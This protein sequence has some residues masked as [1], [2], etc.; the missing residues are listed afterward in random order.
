MPSIIGISITQMQQLL[1]VPAPKLAA[2]HK[3][4]VIGRAA[5][6]VVVAVVLLVCC[7]CWH[8]SLPVTV[9]A[10]KAGQPENGVVGLQGEEHSRAAG[11]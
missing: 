2:H 3:S 8:A 9:K 11:E 7:C 1:A 10:H 5:K 6:M 4:A